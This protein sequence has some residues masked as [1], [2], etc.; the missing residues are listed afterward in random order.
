[1]IKSVINV[2]NKWKIV[3]FI[4]ID[5]DKYNVVESALTDILTPTSVIE[6][7][8]DKI[9][10]AYNSGFTYNNPDYRTSVVGINKTT[11]RKEMIN[12]I[13][14]EAS[15]VQAAIC[16]Y[17]NIDLD[18]ED[19]AYLIGYIVEHFYKACINCFCN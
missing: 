14:H 19:S 15:H 5:Y 10:Y 8:Y 12:T 3:L 17:Y 2:D 7:I 18:T 6:D 16:D 4:N 11:S 13:A 9:G 1:M